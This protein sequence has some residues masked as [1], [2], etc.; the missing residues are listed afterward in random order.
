[1]KVKTG[2][3]I[4]II[5]E[6]KTLIYDIHVCTFWFDLAYFVGSQNLFVKTFFCLYSLKQ[7][8]VSLPYFNKIADFLSLVLLLGY[9]LRRD[10]SSNAITF[11][12]DHVLS[13]QRKLWQL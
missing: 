12:P 11:L 10:L 5:G 13:N 1:M 8:R 7:N 4:D 3:I 2:F 9:S 6:T